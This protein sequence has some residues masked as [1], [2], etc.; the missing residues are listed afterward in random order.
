MGG[1]LPPPPPAGEGGPLLSPFRA[2]NGRAELRTVRARNTHRLIIISRSN[3]YFQAD[4]CRARLL[5][6]KRPRAPDITGSGEIRGEDRDRDRKPTSGG[7][8]LARNT[9]ASILRFTL[10]S[11]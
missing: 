6:K 2:T 10:A 7:G 5:C 4:K 11:K 1:L 8:R 3:L 9:S